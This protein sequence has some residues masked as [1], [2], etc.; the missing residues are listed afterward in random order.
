MPDNFLISCNDKDRTT[1]AWFV[2]ILSCKDDS[3]YTGITRNITK[4]IHQHNHCKSGSKYTR[5]RRPVELVYYE[6]VE[7][8]SAAAKREHEI[9]QFPPAKKKKLIISSLNTNK[10]SYD[11]NSVLVSAIAKQ[12]NN[13]EAVSPLIPQQ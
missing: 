3:L 12:L 5:A 13:E 11:V 6:E 2:Y 8:K 4:R 7:G 10:Q 9:K 1:E